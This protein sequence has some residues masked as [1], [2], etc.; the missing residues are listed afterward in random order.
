MKQKVFLAGATGAIGM[1]LIPL[2]LSA[3][4]DVAGTTRTAAKA[5]ALKRAGVEPVIVDVFDAEALSAAVIRSRSEVVIH[6]LTDLTMGSGPD[7]MTQARARN[8]RLRIEGTCNLMLAARKAGIR[9][10]IAQSIAWV[11]ALKNSPLNE[12][13][14]LDYDAPAPLLVSTLGILALESTV[15]GDPEITGT[16]LRYGR[17]YGPGTGVDVQSDPRLSV[18]VDAAAQ[19]AL[20]A[21]THSGHGVYNITETDDVVTSAK[22]RGELGW[23]PSFRYTQTRA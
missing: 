3:G 4:Y 17:L 11:Y 23:N 15:L 6:Q 20:L 19:A 7:P 12:S 13:D 14:P 8:A 22:A 1:R 16:V 9:R 10:V 21:L 2:L 5:D 18:H